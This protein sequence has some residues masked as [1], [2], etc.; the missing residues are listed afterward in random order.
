MPV[1]SGQV[2]KLMYKG[3]PIFITVNEKE[4]NEWIVTWTNEAQITAYLDKGSSGFKNTDELRTEMF[5][6]DFPIMMTDAQVEKFS[7]EF[8][9][10]VEDYKSFKSSVRDLM[11]ST[12]SFAS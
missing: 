6:D 9:N 8:F 12:R 10:N 4:D 5:T 1:E 7:I 3:L 2:R 11:I